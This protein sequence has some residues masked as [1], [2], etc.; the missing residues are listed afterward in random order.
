MKRGLF[1]PIKNYVVTIRFIDNFLLKVLSFLK[2]FNVRTCSFK[3]C[4]L[5]VYW[6]QTS[7]PNHSGFSEFFVLKLISKFHFRSVRQALLSHAN[8]SQILNDFYVLPNAALS[9]LCG[10]SGSHNEH[11]GTNRV[12]QAAYV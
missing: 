5:S 8:I 12:L 9:D 3:F 7:Q 6:S 2:T 10:E 4:L 11:I 1:V